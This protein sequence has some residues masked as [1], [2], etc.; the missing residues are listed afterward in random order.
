MV[1]K[2]P[3][4]GYR[5]CSINQTLIYGGYVKVREP[6]YIRVIICVNSI[7]NHIDS[8]TILPGMKVLAWYID[9]NGIGNKNTVKYPYPT[10][11]KIVKS[12]L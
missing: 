5:K 8:R 7:L 3:T 10:G 11:V 6:L 4:H 9:L 1:S 12:S 2:K